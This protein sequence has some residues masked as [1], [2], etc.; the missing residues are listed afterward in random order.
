MKSK[1]NAWQAAICEQLS[2]AGGPLS[3]TELLTRISASGFQ[4]RSKQPRGTLA[5]RVTE[6]VKEKKLERVGHAKY[7]LAQ[8]EGAA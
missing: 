8:Q 4:H 3:I 7:Q 2:A 6:L 1:S 5:A